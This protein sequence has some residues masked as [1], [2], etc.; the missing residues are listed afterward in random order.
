[1]TFK[2]YDFMMPWFYESWRQWACVG[3]SML[4]K[5][6]IGT[7]EG[8]EEGGPVRRNVMRLMKGLEHILQEETTL[9]LTTFKGSLHRSLR[10]N[11]LMSVSLLWK[12]RHNWPV[13]LSLRDELGMSLSSSLKQ[14]FA[15]CVLCCGHQAL[16][17][18][19][20]KET[21]FLLLNCLLLNRSF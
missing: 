17:A 9:S 3:S 7:E 13:K 21:Q 12:I 5:E 6:F 2:V 14:N 8:R 15:E 18:Q 19:R 20:W 10:N 1:M 11:I 16:G 4:R